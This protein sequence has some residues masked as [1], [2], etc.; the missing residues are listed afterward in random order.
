VGRDIPRLLSQKS[1]HGSAWM[2]ARPSL[3]NQTS[4]ASHLYRLGLKWWLGLPIVPAN[5]VCTACNNT[6]DAYGDHLLCCKHNNFAKRHNAVQTTLIDSLQMARVPHQREAALALHNTGLSLQQQLSPA[7]ILLF[8][9]QHS[10]DLALDVTI[11]HPAQ[12][13]E[14]PFN[15]EKART[16]LT[17]KEKDKHTKYDDP[18]KK[19]GWCFS[20]FAMDTWGDTGPQAYPLLHRIVQ[21]C[22]NHIPP[23]NRGVSQ[24][25]MR[26]RISIALMRQVWNQLAPS[27]TFWT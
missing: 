3:T 2:E 18:C 27:S 23:R 17:R 9:W 7:D 11:S 1:G 8:S 20:P 19:Q 21:K 24:I 6:L 12:R 16:F 10:R 4:I 15:N 26:Q 14:Q 5:T 25:E 22:T 13:T